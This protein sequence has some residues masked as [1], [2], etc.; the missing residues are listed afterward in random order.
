[1][2][3]FG[4]GVI[5][6]TAFGQQ[7]GGLSVSATAGSTTPYWS[8]V[9]EETS[10]PVSGEISNPPAFVYGPTFTWSIPTVLY[11]A[12][13]PPIAPAEG[14]YYAYFED[15]NA[16]QTTLK[17][18]LYTAGYWHFDLRLDVYGLID[19]YPP[20][21]VGGTAFC[22]AEPVAADELVIKRQKD[23]GNAYDPIGANNKDMLPGEYVDLKVEDPN[24]GAVANIQWTVPATIFKDY[25]SS[26]KEAKKTDVAAND[27]KQQV[28]NFF[29]SDSGDKAVSVQATVGGK[30]GKAKA[31]LSV[32]QPTTSLTASE[33]GDVYLVPNYNP[34]SQPGVTATAFGVFKDKD[35]TPPGIKLSGKVQVPQGFA[36]GSWRFVQLVNS[37]QLSLKG[38]DELLKIDTGGFVLDTDL[39]YKTLEKGGKDLATGDTAYTMVDTLEAYCLLKNDTMEIVLDSAERSDAFKTYIMFKP[40]GAKSQY[41][42]LKRFDWNW[43]GKAIR[44][45]NAKT[46]TLQKG[47]EAKK[48]DAAAD[49]AKHPEW[50]KNYTDF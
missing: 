16:A 34:P 6:D 24:G 25:T 11:A 10:T 26:T 14:G 38:K 33:F 49:D 19:G 50:S 42:P 8:L 37:K 36:E 12:S 32:K 43:S 9:G 30:P 44:D 21:P 31:T 41:V 15:P 1:M 7:P 2:L 18:T 45:A 20:V 13:P 5:C 35:G 29:W 4:F 27:L 46:Y 47:A 23:G 28:I 40:A 48:A 22:A 39:P 3:F 17:A